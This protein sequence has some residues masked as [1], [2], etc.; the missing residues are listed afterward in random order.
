MT[1]DWVMDPTMKVKEVVKNLEL[2][3][4]EINDFVRIKIGE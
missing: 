4:L 2:S 1:Q 3:N